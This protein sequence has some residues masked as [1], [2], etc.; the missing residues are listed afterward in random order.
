MLTKEKAEVEE[1]EPDRRAAGK[2]VKSNR[3]NVLEDM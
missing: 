2:G 1:H 3:G